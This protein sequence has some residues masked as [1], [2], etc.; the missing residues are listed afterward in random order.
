MLSYCETFLSSETCE[1]LLDQENIPQIAG[2]GVLGIGLLLFLKN[3]C[4]S[5]QTPPKSLE[6]RVSKSTSQAQTTT[7]TSTKAT[8][9]PS[10][11]AVQTA[12]V[13][14]L[15]APAS[16]TSVAA[17][18][19][20]KDKQL[21]GAAQTPKLKPEGKSSV[22]KAL[23]PEEILRNKWKSF[24]EDVRTAVSTNN[25]EMVDR[26]IIANSKVPQDKIMDV[27]REIV[28]NRLSAL[29][30][31]A[32]VY[33]I[34]FTPAKILSISWKSIMNKAAEAQEAAAAAQRAIEQESAAAKATKEAAEALARTAPSE[35]YLSL[36][37]KDKQ[38]VDKEIAAFP[39]YYT[40]ENFPNLADRHDDAWKDVQDARAKAKKT[41]KR[42]TTNSTKATPSTSIPATAA[43]SP[44]SV[45]AAPAPAKRSTKAA[46]STSIP[47]TP[48]PARQPTAHS[49]TSVAAAPT[50]AKQTTAAAP[51]P[52]HRETSIP[53]ERSA[54][55]GNMAHTPFSA[56][57]AVDPATLRA[58][59]KKTPNSS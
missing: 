33:K 39:E 36:S 11:Q 4:C 18:M 46:P 13:T 31:E 54:N 29:G 41:K 59:L 15:P 43:H 10:K 35:T 24:F 38:A 12:T 30:W 22:A 52:Q 28:E 9:T 20:N 55:E 5:G 34:D 6:G 50:P 42:K 17:Q 48:A 8:P 47:T 49:S 56:I 3:T 19:P 27:L 1:F 16:P 37:T 44:T 25:S 14:A 23:S 7:K 26:E 51:T 57:G 21:Q 40:E 58:N 2:A 53:S 45:A 32:D